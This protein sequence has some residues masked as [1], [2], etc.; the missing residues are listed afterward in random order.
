MADESSQV[1]EGAAT[2]ERAGIAEDRATQ[3]FIGW[4]SRVSGCEFASIYARNIERKSHR[5][6]KAILCTTALE[7]LT[8]DDLLDAEQLID[9]AAKEKQFALMLF[10]RLRTAEDIAGLLLSLASHPRWRCS[11][12]AWRKHPRDADQLLSL[13]WI[14]ADG[15]PS[16]AI[17]FAP[18]G[19]MP[20]T[21]RAPYVAIA[22]WSGGHENPYRADKAPSPT[23]GLVD[24]PV[25]MKRD[26][27]E[28]L[29]S[30]TRACVEDLL[31]DPPEDG[32]HLQKVS[33]C[34]PR[35]SL[36]KH[37]SRIQEL[38]EK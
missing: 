29:W 38:E 23:I 31:R 1:T 30:G 25:S 16:S 10:P 26:E 2:G 24:Y 8:S 5:A 3:H 22:L 35:S 13:N 37:S 20:V 36:G 14:T 7:D 15:T 11:R 27:Y 32:W 12:V 9:R 6:S 21:R 17:G 33:F 4:L 18:I 19:S 34:L 28:N